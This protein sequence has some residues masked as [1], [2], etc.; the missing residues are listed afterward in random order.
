MQIGTVYTDDVIFPVK[1]IRRKKSLSI[2][3][4]IGEVT[5]YSSGYEE[6]FIE[7]TLKLF[8]QVKITALKNFLIVNADYKKNS[9]QIIPDAGIDLGNGAGISVSARYW[10]EEFNSSYDRDGF[11]NINLMFRKEV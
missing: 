4:T 2:I 6:V 8:D 11:Y 10:S 7:M 9:F 5:S 1:I 3:N